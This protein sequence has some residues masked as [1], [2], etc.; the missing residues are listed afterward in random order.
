MRAV[1]VP[2]PGVIEVTELPDPEPATDGVVVQ[3]AAVGICGTDLHILDG[4]H[5][6]LPV[7]PGHELS[8]TVVATGDAVT[9]VRIGDRVAVDPSLPCRICRPCRAGRANLCPDLGALG[10]T[11]A[12]GAA[13]FVAAPSA[14][15]VVL[16][17]A[18]D[19]VLAALVEPLSCAVRAVDVLRTRIGARVLL[20][21][22]GTMGLLLLELAKRTGA[23]SVDVVDLNATKLVRAR[24]FGCSTAV[25]S[26]DGLEQPDGWDVVV[27]ATGSPAAIADGLTRVA[28][29]GT[30]LQFGVSAP[31]ARVSIA[32]FDVYRREITVTGSMAVLHSFARAADLLGVGFL[33]AAALVTSTA[34]LADYASALG[35]VRGGE[36]LKTLVLPGW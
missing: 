4:H 36:G 9:S 32:P 35:G 22:A 34:P 1:L 16:D 20:Y 11:T 18:V 29:G 14:S 7:V 26:A 27:D 8:G 12:G 24:A 25:E 10:V 13:E 28:A 33:D 17:D 2:A 30:F 21:G 6:R 23:V 31:D 15:C 19:L 5:G 3:V